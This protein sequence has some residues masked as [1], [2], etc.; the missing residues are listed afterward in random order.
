MTATRRLRVLV[1]DDQVVA[2]R[3]TAWYLDALDMEVVG[4]VDDPRQLHSAYVQH[5]PDVVVFE[6]SMGPRGVASAEMS[7]L[8]V[9]EPACAVLVFTSELSPMVVSQAVACGCLGIVPKTSSMAA[10]GAAVRATA[11][12]EQHLHPRAIAALMASRSTAQVEGTRQLSAR[13]LAILERIAE[14]STNGEIAAELGIG[15][16]TVKTHVARIL[17]KLSARDRTHAVSRALRSGL[18]R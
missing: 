10:F 14:G 17:D 6:I 12:G 7:A 5:R 4:V 11:G 13:E 9:A 1:A 18:L 2:A 15:I 8:L 3:G 16:D